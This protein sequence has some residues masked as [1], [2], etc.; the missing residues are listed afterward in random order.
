MIFL[1]VGF[2]PKFER[3]W[4]YYYCNAEILEGKS[5]SGYLNRLFF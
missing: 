3:T 2:F 4:I 5:I 1:F